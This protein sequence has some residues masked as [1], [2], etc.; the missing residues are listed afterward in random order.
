MEK[1]F[2]LDIESTGIDPAAEDLLQVG[3]LEVDWSDGFWWPGRSLEMVF[4]T[5]RKPESSFA[6]EHMVALYERCNAAAVLTPEVARGHILD[7][8][9]NCDAGGPDTYLMGWNA[10]NF[11]VP[12]LV[13]KGVLR[14]SGYVPGPDGKD[15][16]V[17][18]FHYRIYELGG[19]VSLAQNVLRST[20]RGALLEAAKAAYPMNPWAGKEHDALYDCYSQLRLIN[21]LIKLVRAGEANEGR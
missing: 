19:S 3:L 11:D 2:M 7:F 10:S 4:H 15:V 14:P 16:R 8:F 5:D 12:F 1:H 6:K 21:G 20:D 18:D 17:G 13:A 9:K